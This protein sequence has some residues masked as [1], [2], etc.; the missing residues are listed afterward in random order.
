MNSTLNVVEGR[1]GFYPCDYD[2]YQKIRKIYNAYLKSL[3]QNASWWRWT[4]KQPQNRVIRRWKRD[5]QGRRCGC[6]IVGKRP[7]PSINP[8]FWNMSP[9]YH[10]PV[11]NRVIID[12]V[13]A[14][15]RRAR[16]PMKRAEDVVSLSMSNEEIEN[17]F[18][19]IV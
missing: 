11:M 9:L 13:I 7:E 1:F 18:N 10:R 2:T 12:K 5:A 6:E 4:N 15:Y 3:S 14:D 19:S 16:Y 17:L 8:V